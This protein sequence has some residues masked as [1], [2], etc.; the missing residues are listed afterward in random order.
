MSIFILSL[1]VLLIILIFIVPATVT[2]RYES[3]S[4]KFMLRCS[5]LYPLL[6]SR[7]QWVGQN[8]MLRVTVLGI[9]VTSRPLRLKKQSQKP[10]RFSW[11]DLQTL[12]SKDTF[13][14]IDYGTAPFSTGVLYSLIMMLQSFLTDVEFIVHPN[15][16]SEADYI[17]IH[18]GTSLNIGR[19]AVSFLRD[20]LS[21]RKVK[22]KQRGEYYGSVQFG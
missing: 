2:F 13:I 14:R 3:E 6:C 15:F 7:I 16:I 17:C 10:S 11:R 4:G 12:S 21:Q 5:F 22:K 19:T 20:R 9:P 8:L 1:L 18:A